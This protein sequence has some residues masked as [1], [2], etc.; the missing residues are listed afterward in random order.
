[1]TMKKKLAV[2]TFITLA[3]VFSSTSGLMGNHAVN[4]KTNVNPSTATAPSTASL[5]AQFFY[6]GVQV[7]ALGANNNSLYLLSGSRFNR[8]GAISP[9]NGTI[10]ECDF[11]PLNNQLICV[12]NT[13]NVYTVNPANASATFVGAL[14][15]AIAERYPNNIGPNEIGV[16]LR[17]PRSLQRETQRL[18][19]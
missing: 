17:T 16:P 6:A 3:F 2:V 19:G 7:Y 8:V 9:V 13:S 10:A 1:M 4:A 5:S 12:T 18:P 11:R 14:S 15:P